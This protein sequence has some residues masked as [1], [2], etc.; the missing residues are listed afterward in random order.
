M[1]TD[2]KAS[3]FILCRFGPDARGKYTESIL[4]MF[5]YKM[6]CSKQKTDFC[7]CNE[8]K[9]YQVK[10]GEFM[11]YDKNGGSL[12]TEEKTSKNMALALIVASS[13][14][15]L[16]AIAIILVVILLICRYKRAHL[17]VEDDLWA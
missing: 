3:L 15:V 14:V 9:L 12:V 17:Q 6:L 5:D 2:D 13:A 7:S 1:I 11:K 10:N 4:S 16:V 8:D